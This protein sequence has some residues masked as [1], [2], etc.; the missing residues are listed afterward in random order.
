MVTI[1]KLKIKGFGRFSDT[2]IDLSPGLNVVFGGNEAGKSTLHRFIEAVLFGFWEPNFSHPQ[3]EE[4]WSRYKPWNNANY[5]GEIVYC[6]PGGKVLVRRDFT[7]DAVEV[8]DADSGQTIADIPVNSWG[9]PDIAKAH[10]GC[11]KLVFRNTISIS[12]LGAATDSALVGEVKRIVTN[13]AQSGGSGISVDQALSVLTTADEEL[14]SKIDQ[15]KEQWQQLSEQL[16]ANRRLHKEARQLELEKLRVTQ[17]LDTTSL[18][19]QQEQKRRDQS[20]AVIAH[21]KLQR[22]EEHQAKKEALN[23]QLDQL[24]SARPVDEDDL[25]RLSTLRSD[26]KSAQ[27]TLGG[28]MAAEGEAERM[29]RQAIEKSEELQS[30]TQFDRDSAVEISSAY[31]LLETHRTTISQLRT[32]LEELMGEA[33]R[34]AAELSQLPYFRPDAFEQAKKLH[35]QAQG[36]QIQGSQQEL[37]ED[38][39]KLERSAKIRGF[40]R[41]T[42]IASLPAVAVAAWYFSYYLAAVAL[43]PLATIALINGEIRKINLNCRDLRREIYSLDMEFHNSQRQREQAQRSLNELLE[44]HQSRDIQE[45]EDRYQRFSELTENNRELMQEQKYLRG[46]VEQYEQEAREQ[47]EKI[48]DI[49][50]RAGLNAEDMEQGLQQ[51]RSGM[52]QLQQVSLLVEQRQQ[53]LNDVREKLEQSRQNVAGLEK[54]I[55]E[56]LNSY[57]VKSGEELEQMAEDVKSRKQLEKEISEI[58]EQISQLLEGI[59]LEQLRQQAAAAAE[60][61]HDFAVDTHEDS[62]NQHLQ[63]LQQRL[64]QLEGRLEGIYASLKSVTEAEE[65]AHV[66]RKTYSQLQ[67]QAESLEIA[68]ASISQTASQLRDQ[69]APELNQRVS[70]MVETISGGRYKDLNVAADMTITVVTPENKKPVSLDK[71]SGGTIDQFYFACRVAI[72]DLV[73]GQGSLPLL[74]DDSF[75]QYDDQRLERMLSLLVEMSRARQIILFTCQQRELDALSR[76]APDKHT[77]LR[78][79]Q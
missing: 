78:L 73:T 48:K 10:W 79:D 19:H 57:R 8:L 44:K 2:T 33:K 31:K 65:A 43:L 17:Q 74:L 29:Y 70:E 1:D 61:P 20:K 25:A 55:N 54:Q 39:R 49:L 26:L 63:Q 18:E 68:S 53:Q 32:Q 66:A 9:E 23:Q 52:E 67:R 60:L 15:A 58:Q 42:M 47:E 62:Q 77:L 71:L 4:F 50:S 3:R 37:T 6:W 56:I 28:H 14:K 46:K 40:L 13:L 51:F 27:E 35:L 22:I 16:E 69:L 64:S 38:L 45:I 12:Q 7:G 5:A 30:F 76:L 24:S 11:S 36:S 41:M 21:R 34:T 75:V 59:T 72:A